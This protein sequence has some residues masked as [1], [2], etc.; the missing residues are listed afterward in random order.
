MGHCIFIEDSIE[1]K[2]V[3]ENNLIMK[4]KISSSLLMSDLKASS[5]WITMPD[6]IIRNNRVA[7]A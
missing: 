3:I 1:T 2:N 4:T 5:I 7:G 6:N